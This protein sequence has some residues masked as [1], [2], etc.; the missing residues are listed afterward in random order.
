MMSHWNVLLKLCQKPYHIGFIIQLWWWPLADFG[1]M[2]TTILTTNWILN[3]TLK[4]LAKEILDNTNV[5]PKIHMAIMKAQLCY[6]VII[7]LTLYWRISIFL[8]DYLFDYTSALLQAKS[9]F[10]IHFF[11]FQNWQLQQNLLC[12]QCMKIFKVYFNFLLELMHASSNFDCIR[13]LWTLMLFS[14]RNGW[15]N[16]ECPWKSENYLHLT[17]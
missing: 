9:F 11:F 10:F 3:F 6:M 8:L 14:E 7:E 17:A 13:C 4:I 2:N 12:Q 15:L 1:L 5:C 16:H